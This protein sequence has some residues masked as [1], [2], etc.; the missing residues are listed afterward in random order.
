[1]T[2][3]MNICYYALIGIFAQNLVFTSGV[4]AER[5]LRM[6]Y[7][8][9]RILIATAAVTFFSLVSVSAMHLIR[10]L[11]VF[12]PLLEW[13]RV[14]LLVALLVTVYM[15]ILWICRRSPSKI[16][17][18]VAE[19]LPSGVFNTVVIMVGIT[20]Q[21]LSMSYGQAVGYAIGTGFGFLLATLLVQESIDRIENPATPPAF[22]GLPTL[23]IYIGIL[24][25]AFVGFT[26]GPSLFL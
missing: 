5:A 21:M 26:G 10:V 19:A 15:G 14:L 7:R 9:G 16:F 8:R 1:M 11:S 20:S 12:L 23:L 17:K 4:G 25:M 18:A 3:F 24:S 22:V 2:V 6:P 13:I